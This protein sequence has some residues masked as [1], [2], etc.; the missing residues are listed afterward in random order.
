MDTLIAMFFTLGL[1]G[2]PAPQELPPDE[3]PAATMQLLPAPAIERHEQRRQRIIATNDW[4]R[5][6][7]QVRGSDKASPEP[8]SVALRTDTPDS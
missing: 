5:E 4:L 8:L 1:M 6:M 3:P 2:S 7:R